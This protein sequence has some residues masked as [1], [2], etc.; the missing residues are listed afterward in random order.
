MQKE[1]RKYWIYLRGRQFSAGTYHWKHGKRPIF[2]NYEEGLYVIF[3]M[4]FE[5]NKRIAL[6]KLKEALIKNSISWIFEKNGHWTI[7]INE[8]Y[9]NFPS[10]PRFKWLEGTVQPELEIETKQTLHDSKMK[11]T[12]IQFIITKKEVNLSMPKRIFLSHKS[13]DKPLVR[14]YFETL[15]AIGFEPWLD[16]D[17]MTAGSTIERALIAGMKDSCAAVFFITPSYMDENFLASEINYAMEKKREKADRFSI[18]TLVFSDENGR[19]G[20][21]PDLLKQFVWKEPKNNLQGIKEIIRALP[22]EV[23]QISW[24]DI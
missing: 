4:H 7:K 24:K 2:H 21:V 15:K 18:I 12:T 9:N 6:A 5:Y 11:E 13:C 10:L 17:A 8:L 14:E 19:K 16:E 1:D 20:Q 22:I 23:K 3:P